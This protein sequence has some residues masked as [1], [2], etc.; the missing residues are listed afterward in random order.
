VR[1]VLTKMQLVRVLAEWSP[2]DVDVFAV[3]PRGGALVPKTRA[4]LGILVRWYETEGG[5]NAL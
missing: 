2:T 1:P 4:F 3:T 5:W